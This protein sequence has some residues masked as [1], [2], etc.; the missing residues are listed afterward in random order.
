MKKF[1]YTTIVII[2]SFL[3]LILSSFKSN[4]KTDGTYDSI[5]FG[6][7]A[8]SGIYMGSEH[9]KLIEKLGTPDSVVKEENEIKEQGEFFETYVYG[10]DR[11]LVINDTFIGFELNSDKL[12]VSS[13]DLK[14]GDNIAKAK[15]LFPISFK[16]KDVD[17]FNPKWMTMSVQLGDSDSFMEI[18]SED[19][20]IKSIITVTDGE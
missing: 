11:L 19:D 14:V 10:K 20:K 8:I 7:L 2:V 13:L 17:E 15:K 12:S 16:N 5:D 3:F 1:T 9:G 18:Y 6:S 4:L